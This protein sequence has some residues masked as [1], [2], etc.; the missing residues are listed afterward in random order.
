MKKKIVMLLLLSSTALNFNTT[1]LAEGGSG[2]GGA[3]VTS[4]MS[5]CNDVVVGLEE[6]RSDA[7]SRIS[8]GQNKIEAINIYYNGLKNAAAQAEN[9]PV[10]LGNSLTYRTIARGVRL[11][12][13]LGADD[14]LSG[15]VGTGLAEEQK[16]QS[17]VSFLDW[18]YS[19]ISEVSD[20]VDKT[21]Y[22][23]Y[24]YHRDCRG[25][26]CQSDVPFHTLDLEQRMVEV[27]V[28]ALTEL[29]ARFVNV[30][31][32]RD[33]YYT[34]IRVDLYTKALAYLTSE[35]A[36]DLEESLFSN[37]LDC[38]VKRLK[39]LSRKVQF[40]N[41]GRSTNQNDAIKLNEFT[42]QLNFITR[43]LTQRTCERF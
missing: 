1:A 40:Y 30:R 7:L 8:Y 25:S 39:S 17:L 9:S 18:Y 29:S 19:Y 37:A 6:S 42:L 10:S 16:V 15:G 5:W 21:F 4:M 35:V 12:Q 14:V 13:Y 43:Q 34:T 28:K 26:Y 23:P 36:I 27:S 41:N 32:A 2:V 20:T 31:S 38:Q 22:I 24:A 33:S 11:A 3:V